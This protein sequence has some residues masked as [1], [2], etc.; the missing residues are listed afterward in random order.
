MD[1]DYLLSTIE[2]FNLEITRDE[3]E[4]IIIGPCPLPEDV[5][6]Q[7]KDMF[8]GQQ[9]KVR[10]ITGPKML[11][12]SRLGTIL[13]GFE[14]AAARTDKTLTFMGDQVPDNNVW[15][16]VIR[17]VKEDGFYDIVEF[18]VIEVRLRYNKLLTFPSLK[19]DTPINEDDILNLK[20]A[21]AT[22]KSVEDFEKMVCL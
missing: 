10:F 3:K 9:L 14:V 17:A 4:V 5:T 21:L 12:R 1:I 8:E 16:E 22:A 19:R 6:R 13:E 15:G 18:K 11:L 2:K 20:I 7:L